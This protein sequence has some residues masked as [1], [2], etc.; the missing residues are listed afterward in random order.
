MADLGDHANELVLA[1]L[2]GLLAPRPA[3]AIRQTA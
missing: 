1:L 2:D 3:L